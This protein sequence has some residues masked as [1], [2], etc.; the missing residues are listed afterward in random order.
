MEEIS[1]AD[2]DDDNDDARSTIE[3][4]ESSDDDLRVELL[5][6]EEAAA[7][8]AAHAAQARVSLLRARVA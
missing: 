1:I 3:H 5:E 7:R 2:S 8:L 6:A 4:V